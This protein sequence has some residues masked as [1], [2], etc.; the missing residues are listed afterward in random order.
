MKSRVVGQ[1]VNG[2]Q[3]ISRKYPLLNSAV[4]S[5]EDG[6]SSLCLLRMLSLHGAVIYTSI[7][8]NIFDAWPPKEVKTDSLTLLN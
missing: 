4:N 8:L 1:D 2:I 5:F 3:L 7:K 6:L